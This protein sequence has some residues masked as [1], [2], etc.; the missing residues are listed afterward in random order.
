MILLITVI[1]DLTALYPLPIAL[2]N[3]WA[4]LRQQWKENILAESERGFVYC[5]VS[6]VG[7]K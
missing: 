4:M 2:Q 6:N 7:T 5:T 3:F 1:Y